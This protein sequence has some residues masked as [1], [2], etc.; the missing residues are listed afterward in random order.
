MS[1]MMR[2]LIA[3]ATTSLLLLAANPPALPCSVF[4]AHDAQT[5]LAG[6]NEDY[7]GGDPTIIWFVPPENGNS[8]CSSS[9]HML[10]VSGIR[11]LAEI[12]A[13]ATPRKQ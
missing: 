5:V 12:P 10:A 1:Y 4:T 11:T 6:N 3:L 8:C 2:L 7:Y 13:F 9:P